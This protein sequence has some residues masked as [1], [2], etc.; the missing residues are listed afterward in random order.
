MITKRIALTRGQYWALNDDFF[1]EFK[2]FGWEDF[3]CVH[4]FLPITERKEVDTYQILAYFKEALPYLKIV[5][6]KTDIE[7]K[8]IIPIVFDHEHTVL[9]KNKYQIPEP[10]YGKQCNLDEIEVVL[11]PL[12]AFDLSGNRVGYGA[13][14]YDKFLAN[15]KSSS[16]KIGLS[17]FAPIQK[18][19]DVNS[20]D[21][22]LT[23]CITPEKTYI[24]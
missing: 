8:Q 17:L 21:V 4:L 9:I 11:I 12:L 6:N 19:D 5:V 24:F 15:C 23:H 20:F 13:G 3:G 14:Y 7:K 2:K 18:I 10:L 22:K 1:E 16:L